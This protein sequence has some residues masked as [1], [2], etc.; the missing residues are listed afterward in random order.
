MNGYCSQSLCDVAVQLSR[1][2]GVQGVIVDEDSSA[3]PAGPGIVVHLVGGI[4]V[5]AEVVSMAVGRVEV[6]VVWHAAAR[7]S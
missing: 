5:V 7:E 4:G 2:H 6:V 3:V 1:W